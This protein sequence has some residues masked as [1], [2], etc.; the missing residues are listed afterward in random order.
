MTVFL[1]FANPISV[2]VTSMWVL[3]LLHHRWN[4]THATGF[5]WAHIYFVISQWLCSLVFLLV[6]L[7]ICR[8]SP[9]WFI[10]GLVYY[11]NIQF[12]RL[13]VSDSLRPYG[14]QHARLPCPSPTPGACSN[15]C[16]LSR[17]RHPTISSS[18]DRFSCL[19][20]FP[21]SEFCPMSQF[22]ASGGQKYQHQSFQWIF[23]TNFL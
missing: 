14:L 15:S 3:A 11:N 10:K 21:A 1:F 5:K 13:I 23:R 22:F 16:P 20:S 17:W 18:V 2:A 6:G 7:F 4:S 9:N 19:Q 8:N 12:I